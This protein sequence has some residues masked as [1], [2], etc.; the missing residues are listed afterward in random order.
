MA[1]RLKLI[2]TLG[3]TT[4]CGA[5]QG[6]LPDPTRPPAD[7]APAPL[8]GEVAAQ[9]G[10]GLQSVILH[11]D[12]RPAALINGQV[13][14]LGGM[15]GDTRLVLVEEDAVVLLGPQGRETLRLMP[16]VEKQQKVDAGKTAKP[17]GLNAVKGEKPR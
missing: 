2:L 9:T 12:R 17:V 1:G 5:A 13:V 8:A 16:A 14:E 3:A 4:L 10:G 15:L 6:D 11:K 7:V